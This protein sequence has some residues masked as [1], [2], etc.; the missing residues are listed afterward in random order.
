MSTMMLPGKAQATTGDDNTDLAQVSWIYAGGAGNITVHPADQPGTS[1]TVAVIAG[2]VI[3]F[4]VRRV[5]ST[6]LTATGV[7]AFWG[8]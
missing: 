5:L 4:Q 8:E 7:I 1:V 6:G 3:P 2:G